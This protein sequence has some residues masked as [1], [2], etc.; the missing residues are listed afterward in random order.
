MKALI[1]R[2]SQAR[3]A[4]ELHQFINLY[5]ASSLLQR[6]LILS[7]I[8]LFYVFAKELR[9]N[10]NLYVAIITLLIG[11]YTLCRVVIG[12]CLYL[13]FCAQNG[14]SLNPYKA[15]TLYTAKEIQREIEH[16]HWSVRL[17]LRMVAGSPEKFAQE[18][19]QGAV[20]SPEIS[21]LVAG[22]AVYYGM[23][24]AAYMLGYNFLYEKMI[25]IDF[26]SF[27]H[28]FTWAWLYLITYIN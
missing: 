15:I 18:I 16:N 6:L 4:R 3:V 20:H 28:P 23:V 9:A 11:F 26:H 8:V 13:L 21:R 17:I 7:L 14:F 25:N 12:T 2:Y 5:F 24:V 10:V 19:A 22:R 1:A 27:I